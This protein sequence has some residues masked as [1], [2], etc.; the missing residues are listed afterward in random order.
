M[1]EP[2]PLPRKTVL[3][4]RPRLQ[5][6]PLWACLEDAGF[7]VLLQPTVEIVPLFDFTK[8][9]P[10]IRRLLGERGP[11]F[12]WLIFASRNGVRLFFERFR[13]LA[14]IPD[15]AA[16]SI[17][18]G[19]GF[20]DGL[21]IAVVGRGTGEALQDATGRLPDLFSPNGSLEEIRD[22]LL[23]EP[24]SGRRYLIARAD[25]GRDIL[26]KPL[27]GAGAA[28]VREIVVYR[29]VD[30]E[31]PNPDIFQELR[32]GRVDMATATSSAIAASLVRMFGPHLHKTRLVSLG[33]LTSGTLTEL[34]FPPVAEAE[35]TTMDA[36]FIALCRLGNRIDAS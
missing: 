36:L 20:L 13:K 21:R 2:S 28:E 10:P 11:A 1:T 18:T 9:D 27:L 4:T 30:V 35:T 29:S 19:K 34:G 6:G 17:K 3:L 23:R 8:V 14:D 22:A 16:A 24:V 5:C 33:P 25:R 32:E 15:I 26:R 12:D 31:K 7:R